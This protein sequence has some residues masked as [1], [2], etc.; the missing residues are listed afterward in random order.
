MSHPKSVQPNTLSA[1]VAMSAVGVAHV[2]L[3]TISAVL[4]MAESPAEIVPKFEPEVTPLRMR[5]V[6][7]ITNVKVLGTIGPDTSRS[8]R[9]LFQNVALPERTMTHKSLFDHGTNVRLKLD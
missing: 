8:G 4:V 3:S 1:G 5:E 6:R 2:I 7:E 9:K